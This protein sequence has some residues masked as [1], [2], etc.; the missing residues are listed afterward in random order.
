[1]Q[2][3]YDNRE[4]MNGKSAVWVWIALGAAVAAGATAYFLLQKR[5][6]SET[7]DHWLDSCNDALSL[8]DERAN[9]SISSMAS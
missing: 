3:S 5:Q 2:C 1:M 7:V 6:A 9:S 8:L 4:D